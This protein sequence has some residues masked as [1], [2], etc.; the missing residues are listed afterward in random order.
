V[1]GIIGFED[2]ELDCVIGVFSHERGLKQRLL[3]DIKV[4]TD[5]GESITSDQLSHTLDYCEILR[6]IKEEASSNFK[7][8]EAFAHHVNQRLLRELPITWVW[9]RVKKPS[10][11]PMARHSLVELECFKLGTTHEVDTYNRRRHP[12]RR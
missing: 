5:F 11:N 2:L 4:E 3:I 10:A 9:I 12:A 6:L 1:L 7:L 8:L